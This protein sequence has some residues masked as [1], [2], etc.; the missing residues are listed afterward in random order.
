VKRQ[1]AEAVVGSS[2]RIEALRDRLRDVSAWFD[3]D[4]QSARSARLANGGNGR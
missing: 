2:G 3:Q 1:R 4:A